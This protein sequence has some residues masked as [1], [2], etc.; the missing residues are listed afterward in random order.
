MPVATNG[1]SSTQTKITRHTIK[2]DV[3]NDNCRD[4]RP[5]NI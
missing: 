4:N 1:V 2:Q 5:I 3:S